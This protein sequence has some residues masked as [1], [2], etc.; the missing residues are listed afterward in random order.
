MLF[1]SSRMIL[2]NATILH[3][4]FQDILRML[5]VVSFKFERKKINP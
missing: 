2:L 5:V 4:H 1:G 3:V